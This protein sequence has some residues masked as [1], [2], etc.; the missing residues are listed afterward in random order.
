MSGE[1]IFEALRGI[2]PQYILDADPTA[3]KPSPRAWVKWGALA[4]CLC[5]IAAA[6]IGIVFWQGKGTNGEPPSHIHVFG[7]WTTTKEASCS[8]LGEQTRL[9]AC[10][11]KETQP[12]ALL[13]H[14]AGA[15][16][17]EKEPTIKLPTPSDPSEREA[18]LM[19]Q[20][21]SH[22]GAKLGEELIPATGSL[23][24][25][26]AVNPDGKTFMVAGI[27]NCTDE[28]VIIPENFCGYH[29]TTIGDGAFMSCTTVKSV[30]LPDTITT[31]GNRAFAYCRELVSI[32]LPEGLLQIG[33]QAFWYSQNLESI[34]VPQSV[35]D[36]GKSAFDSCY[37]L[38]SIILPDNLKMIAD[39]LFA[40]C[41]DLKTI[42]LPEG[43]ES[44]GDFAFENC[45]SLQEIVI[46]ASVSGIGKRAFSECRYLT[47]IVLPPL[48]RSI[49]EYTFSDCFRL[50]RIVLPQ[51]V[52]HI[53]RGAF[54]QCLALI[55]IEI[56]TGVTVIG[57]SAFI[58]CKS[59]E[60]VVLPKGLEV[61][62]ELAFL[63][64]E[65]LS[66]INIPDSV[67]RIGRSAFDECDALI[68][69]ENGVG[70]V[71][72]WAVSAEKDLYE[73]AVREGTVGI[74]SSAFYT[75][76]EYVRV[77][78]PGSLKYINKYAFAAARYLELIIFAGDAAAWE[79]VEKALDWAEGAKQFEIIF[80]R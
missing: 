35:T 75:H 41:L 66:E 24:L 36:I 63:N 59:L 10:G 32:A 4:A 18:G 7:E 28:D 2:D 71:E 69:M 13:P 51:Y 54:Y 78:L 29:V 44:I 17:I 1:Q 34:S 25:A 8:E 61:I 50:E 43:L 80:T 15:W 38:K 46:P 30:T 14:F 52:M 57:P 45:I 19:C 31:I 11:E 9:C 39:G 72:N 37:E 27:G 62:E 40:S 74:A 16:V 33:E 22:C 58:N 79:S 60:R 26:Y 76:G 56:P 20:F 55:Q 67:R 21:C 48:V 65:K 3:K 53:E 49:E 47:E 6:A 77:T 68:Q 12:I 70:Y 23:G 42:S 5:L 73:I 64:C